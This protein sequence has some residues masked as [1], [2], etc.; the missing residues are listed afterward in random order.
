MAVSAA[1]RASIIKS[2]ERGVV[3]EDIALEFGQPCSVITAIL[4]KSGRIAKPRGRP[5][6]G[7]PIKSKPSRF[8]SATDKDLVQR[9]L[10][11]HS[12]MQ[13][14]AGHAIG[15]SRLEAQHGVP[16]ARSMRENISRDAE[17]GKAEKAAGMR[18]EI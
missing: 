1:D 14:P 4:T 3:V 2:F 12:I 8:M 11:K 18:R 5:S 13:C 6:A 17:R 7:P 10:E 9:Y 15:T 16:A